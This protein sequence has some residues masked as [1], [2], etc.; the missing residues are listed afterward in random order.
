MALSQAALGWDESYVLANLNE[1]VDALLVPPEERGPEQWNLLSTNLQ[2]LGEYTLKHIRKRAL[3]DGD[4]NSSGTSSTSAKRMKEWA[5]WGQAMEYLSEWNRSAE[6]RISDSRL[7]VG[8]VVFCDNQLFLVVEYFKQ[9][10][11]AKVRC[12]ALSAEADGATQ[13]YVYS[14]PTTKESEAKKEEFIVCSGFQGK[15]NSKSKK[16]YWLLMKEMQ[17]AQ[18]Y[19]PQRAI[20]AVLTR[21]ERTEAKRLEKQQQEEQQIQSV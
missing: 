7:G 13:R 8:R 18:R 5:P 10:S 6:F 15:S 4:S 19:G 12:V 16:S 1:C 21:A 14:I 17:V 2:D 20:R 3:G 11:V 9:G